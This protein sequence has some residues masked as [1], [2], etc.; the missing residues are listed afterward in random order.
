MELAVALLRVGMIG[1]RSNLELK[2]GSLTDVKYTEAVVNE[3]ARLTDEGTRAA[4]AAESLLR[5]P[6]A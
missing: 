1:A 3:I 4:D 5:V 6:P 2:L